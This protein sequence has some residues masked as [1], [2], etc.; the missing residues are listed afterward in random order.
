MIRWFLN[1][2]RPAW[3]ARV[4][5]RHVRGQVNAELSKVIEEAKTAR[6]HF[7]RWSPP[8]DIY[9]AMIEYGTR[10][11]TLGEFDGGDRRQVMIPHFSIQQDRELLTKLQAAVDARFNAMPQMIPYTAAGIAYAQRMLDDAVQEVAFEAQTRGI[12][13]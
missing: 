6:A 7:E 4:A 8:V 13:P 11:L 5:E 9:A 10:L 1:R 3:R 2:R 12:E